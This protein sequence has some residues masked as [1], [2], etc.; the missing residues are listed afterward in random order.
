MVHAMKVSSTPPEDEKIEQH[1]LN[2]NIPKSPSFHSGLDLVASTGNKYVNISKFNF[3]SDMNGNN[4]KTT[5]A[6]NDQQS[7]Q[8]TIFSFTK[9]R[10]WNFL[11]NIRWTFSIF[12]FFTQSN[13]LNNLNITSSI[14]PI[15][16]RQNSAPTQQQQHQ[17]VSQNGDF[18]KPNNIVQKT[19]APSN[20]TPSTASEIQRKYS[21]PM[22]TMPSQPLVPATSFNPPMM[23]KQSAPTIQ[24]MAP[25]QQQF[26]QQ[27]Q[28][29]PHGSP[30]RARDRNYF[31]KVPSSQDVQQL[32]LLKGGRV[33]QLSFS[34]T[35]SI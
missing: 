22:N 19:V 26:V 31:D 7:N 12:Q 4:N 8:Q 1:K 9:V 17:N 30:S 14:P 27:Q 15:L 3:A 13:P 18:Y 21:L 5:T 25:S 24:S 28:M 29:I 11:L 16:Q 2:S 34:F 35:C 10:K 33:A 23:R 6:G 20:P 32:P